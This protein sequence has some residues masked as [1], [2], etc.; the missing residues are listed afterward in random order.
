MKQHIC[1][2]KKDGD[3]KAD[4]KYGQG[5]GIHDAKAGAGSAFVRLLG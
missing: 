4:T 5:N 3:P 2:Q 1:Y